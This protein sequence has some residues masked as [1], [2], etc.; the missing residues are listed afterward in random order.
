MKKKNKKWLKARHR[1]VRNIAYLILRPFSAIKYGIKIERFRENERRQYLILYN[2][3]T[4]F[5]QFFVGMTTK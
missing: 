1:L 4:A 2:H 3:Q 5:D